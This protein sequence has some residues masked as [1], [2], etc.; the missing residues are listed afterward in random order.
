MSEASAPPASVR[1]PGSGGG[2][3]AAL[4]LGTNNCRL[5][6]AVPAGRGYRI[7]DSFSRIVR[8]GEGLAGSGRLS[9]AAM[10]RALSALSLCVEKIHRRGAT[11]VR[12]VA[13]Q[14]CRTAANGP[15][16]LGRVEA[17]IGLKLEVISPKQEARLAVAGCLNLV[18]PAAK[19]V[20]VLD[21]GGGST[22]LSWLDLRRRGLELHP[23]RRQYWNPPITAWL[24]IP[25]GVVSL[26]ERFPG[27]GADDH[28]TYAAMVEAVRSEIASFVRADR[29]R[30]LFERG[31]AHLIGTSGAITSL[32]GL[33]LALP[34]YDRNRVDGLWMRRAECEIVAERL[35]GQSVA[36]RAAEPCIGPDRADLVLAGAA[37]LQAVQTLWPC[38]RVRVADRG[39]REGLLLSLMARSTP[40][41]AGA[42][43]RP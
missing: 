10:A 11:R 43:C 39:L 38:E 4:D 1:H 37:I 6:I 14:A 19:A 8:L 34:R 26:A 17:T 21:V 16:F 42:P 13:T 12:A 7:I 5:L 29:L 3:Y 30:P 24:S 33:H 40:G 22:E 18:D 2:V 27:H 23:R 20:L 32:A 36:E 41:G 9:E 28:A 31:H 25:V 15:E 35:I